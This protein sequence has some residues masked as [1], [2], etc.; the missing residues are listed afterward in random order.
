MRAS[1]IG[2]PVIWVTENSPRYL[3]SD[4]QTWLR[5]RKGVA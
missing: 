3:L 5:S 1:G 2:P 4:V